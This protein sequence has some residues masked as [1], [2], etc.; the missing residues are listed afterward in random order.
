MHHT[1]HEVAG[2]SRKG[3]HRL[4]SEIAFVTFVLLIPTSC[5]RKTESNQRADTSTGAEE[6]AAQN[7][8]P[9]DSAIK[10]KVVLPLK[11]YTLGAINKS[12]LIRKLALA[13]QDKDASADAAM[14]LYQMRDVLARSPM[15]SLLDD[16][17]PYVRSS[18]AFVLEA[19]GGETSVEALIPLLKD[20]R[21]KANAAGALGKIGDRRAIEPLA[22][23]LNDENSNIRW[24]TLDALKDITGEDFGDS[25]DLWLMWW[26]QNKESSSPK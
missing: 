8:E 3:F 12:E 20:P 22:E 24:R 4:L 25:P 13:V 5:L 21:A 18:A 19:V 15:E 9:D 16:E 7:D 17:R 26:Q 6:S 11:L 14:A 2:D 10:E 23:L 1:S